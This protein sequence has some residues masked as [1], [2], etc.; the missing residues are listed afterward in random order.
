MT[1]KKINVQEYLSEDGM[2][3]DIAHLWWLPVSTVRWS[4]KRLRLGKPIRPET[5]RLIF[6]GINK[7][8]G[9]RLIMSDLIW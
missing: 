2:A 5:K 6:E 9:G 4:K 8:E 7:R 3:P 1:D